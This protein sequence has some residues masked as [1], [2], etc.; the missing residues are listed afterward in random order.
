MEPQ[1]TME[2]EVAYARPERQLILRV[3][4]PAGTT[5]LEAARLSGIEE[6]FPE[7]RLDQNRMGIFGKLCK[8][9]RVLNP[10]DRV[11]IYRPLLADPRAARREL[12]AAG[13]SMGKG[14]RDGDD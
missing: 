12:A 6:Q 1:E 7:I 5:A 9:D 14:G 11:E 8:G 3:E 13:K 4:V 10:G 2:V